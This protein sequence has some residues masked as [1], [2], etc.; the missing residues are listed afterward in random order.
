M[1]ETPPRRFTGSS[2][3]IAVQESEIHGRGV[4]ATAPIASGETIEI[5]P[6]LRVPV[7]EVELIDSTLIAAYYYIWNGAAGI[8]LGFGSLYNHSSTPNAE[9]LKHIEEDFLVIRALSAIP[10]GEEITMSYG[11][12]SSG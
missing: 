3:K 9:Y 7:E 5:C 8:A 4:F 11:G 2:G 10:S 6:V 1:T 12:P